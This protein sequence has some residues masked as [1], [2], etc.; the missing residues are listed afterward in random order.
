[1]Q[2]IKILIILADLFFIGCTMSVMLAAEKKSVKLA[3]I[4]CK[5][6][7]VLRYNGFNELKVRKKVLYD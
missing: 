7:L 2:I 3:R 5:C 1:M 4:I 6:Y